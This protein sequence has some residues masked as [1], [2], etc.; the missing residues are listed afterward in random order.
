MPDTQPAWGRA[1]PAL[2]VDVDAE[3]ELGPGPIAAE[4]ENS[5][6]RNSGQEKGSSRV[7]VAVGTSRG[8][9]AGGGSG[10]GGGAWLGQ[11]APCHSRGTD[12]RAGRSNP[13]PSIFVSP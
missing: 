4:A 7:F 13:V 2:D 3:V 5:T 12:R 1:S 8:S 11:I 10:L 9:D 6:N